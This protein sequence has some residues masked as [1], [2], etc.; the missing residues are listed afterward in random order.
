MKSGTYPQLISKYSSDVEVSSIC[1]EATVKVLV[2]VVSKACLV[3]GYV[4]KV[5]TYKELKGLVCTP[6]FVSSRSRKLSL[7]LVKAQAQ[8]I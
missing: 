7:F 5:E 4:R 2:D 6:L 1:V 3:A 8:A